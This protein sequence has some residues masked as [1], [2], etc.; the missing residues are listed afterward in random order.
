MIIID[1]DNY[2]YF[3]IGN[4][5]K[6]LFQLKEKGFNVPNLF[7]VNTK[8]IFKKTFDS[9]LDKNFKDVEFFSVRSSANI[10]DGNN[11]SFAGQFDSYLN[12]SRDELCTYIEKCFSS[13]A[14]T[15]NRD[16]GYTEELKMN[17]II[18]EMVGCDISGVLFSSNPQGI[19]N[20]KVV[21][22]GEGE[23]NLV[24]EDKVDVTTYYYNSSDK[25]YYY[26]TKGDSVVLEDDIFN[27]LIEVCSKIEKEFGKFL[28]LEFGIKDKEIHILQLRRITTITDE[29]R[30][31]LDSSNIVES[32]PGVTLPFTY[33]FI[34]GAYSGVFKN[35]VERTL[36]DKT[37]IGKY[38]HVFDDMLGMSNGRVY[39]KISNW[40]ALIVML[41]FSKKVI[42]IW[43]E[44][45][46]VENKEVLIDDI[47]IDT[48]RNLKLYLNMLQEFF[49][50]NKNMN[51]LQEDFYEIDK[52]FKENFNENA[53]NKELLEIYD[54]MHERVL[55]KWGVTLI[56]DVYAF[57]YTGLLKAR[58]KRFHR[59]SYEKIT[60]RYISNI[61]SIESMKP[62]QALAELTIYLIKNKKINK[63][64]K[65]T[66]ENINEYLETKGKSQ[67]L[68]NRYIEVYG[69]RSIEELKIETDTFRSNP[70]L[71]INQILEYSED[72]DKL[73]LLCEKTKPRKIKHIDP[74]VRYYGEKAVI[75]I[76]NR[77]KSRL[78]R[79][80]C[81]G[82]IRTIMLRDG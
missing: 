50:V 51:A 39:Y 74:L 41:P 33:S 82:M 7:C 4:K 55:S 81:Y 19:I 17:V 63:L 44:M 28:D 76:G 77:E 40:Y 8:Y 64:K 18:Q 65:L 80:R 78:N 66:E 37:E 22:V 15:D 57:V 5:A 3:D 20:E 54:D 16:Y 32:Y 13:V 42:P 36:K 61:S 56:N 27:Q 23:A 67:K 58:L 52:Y 26:E 48:T 31:V 25:Q 11:F 2:P 60:N 6:K 24:V 34:K 53:S 43:Q 45:I 1:V 38:N 72:L 73:E 62:V 9:Y 69:D 59:K 47:K 68:I 21:I 79:S 35:V 12:V 71:L 49:S 75:G 29:N 70:I 10:E 30:V 14:N 46:G